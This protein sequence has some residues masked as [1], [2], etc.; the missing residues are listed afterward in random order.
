MK[1]EQKN[2]SNISRDI[3]QEII[4]I[5]WNS[6]KSFARF[7]FFPDTLRHKRL[8]IVCII[9]NKILFRSSFKHP[10]FPNFLIF[11][12]TKT[13]REVSFLIR[14]EKQTDARFS[15][16]NRQALKIGKLSV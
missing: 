16:E 6:S 15:S 3:N 1:V 8:K 13:E 5:S 12:T 14:K 2:G 11:N 9:Q 7:S 4:R 10:R